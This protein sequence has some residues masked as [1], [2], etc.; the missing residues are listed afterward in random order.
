MATDVDKVF[1]LLI[2]MAMDILQPWG[3]DGFLNVDECG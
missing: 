2:L 3:K 1:F